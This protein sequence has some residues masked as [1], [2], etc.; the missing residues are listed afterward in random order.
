L[1]IAGTLLGL[2]FAVSWVAG[3]LRRHQPSA[4]VIAALALAGAE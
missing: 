1:W 2:V 3:T 4:D